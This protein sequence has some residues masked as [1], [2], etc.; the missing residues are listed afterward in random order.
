[1]KQKDF[2]L[3]GGV[4]IVSIILSLVIAHFIFGG[5]GSHTASVEVVDKITSDFPVSQV[6]GPYFNSQSVDPTQLIEI[7]QPNENPFNG[8]QNQ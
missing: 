2:A 6:Q 5:S 4:L 1:M 7:G 3:L 8:S